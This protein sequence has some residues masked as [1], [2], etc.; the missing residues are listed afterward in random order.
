MA[1]PRLPRRCLNSRWTTAAAA[2]SGALSRRCSN[3]RR[4]RGKARA[5]APAPCPNWYR[6]ARAPHPAP[7]RAASFRGS[8]DRRAQGSRRRAGSPDRQGEDSEHAAGTP[9]RRIRGVDR[10]QAQ[11]PPGEAG[12]SVRSRDSIPERLRPSAASPTRAK[13]VWSLPPAGVAAGR[14][15]AG[16][17]EAGAANRRAR[18]E[19]RAATDR[20][21]I[22][23]SPFPN[24]SG[25]RRRPAARASRRWR[26]CSGSSS[27]I[28]ASCRTRWTPEGPRADGSTASPNG[29]SAPSERRPRSR[30][31]SGRSRAT[32]P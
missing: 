21:S 15:A 14:R 27:T 30:R 7:C 26:R 5:A 6:A 32:S 28:L 11:R 20:R 1:G 3:R 24:R 9:A 23:A 31:P 22:F 2:D 16:R 29:Y 25:A 17:V 19:R 8:P 18:R 13:A 12:D 10:S 4:E